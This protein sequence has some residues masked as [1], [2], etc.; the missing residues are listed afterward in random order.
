[1]MSFIADLASIVGFIIGLPALVIALIQLHRTKRAAEAAAA[2]AREAFQRVATVVAVASLEQI[3]GRCRD[4]LQLIRE[5]DYKGSARTAFELHEA[6]A[7]FSNSKA[8]ISIQGTDKWSEL[9]G[10]VS[11]LHRSL[12]RGAAIRKANTKEL[13]TKVARIHTQI[14]ILSG[15]AGDKAGEINEHSETVP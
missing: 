10:K 6:L 8:A 5:G 14:C 4:V 3:C 7:K 13:I 1:M 12:E 9:S 2:A 15:I 11:E